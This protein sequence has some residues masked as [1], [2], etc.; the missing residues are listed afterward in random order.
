MIS[1]PTR[2]LWSCLLLGALGCGSNGF[3]GPLDVRPYV[4]YGAAHNDNLL[5]V[6]DS[7]ARSDT[8]HETALGTLVEWPVA[9][10]R[11]IA[12]GRVS[13]L[14]YQRFDELDHDEYEARARWEFR[15]GRVVYG[16]AGYRRQRYLDDFDNRQQAVT[17]FID[18]SEPSLETYVQ[19]HPDWRIRTLVSHLK[20]DHSLASQ[21]RF[22]REET[23]ASA[24]LQ[25]QGVESSLF[26]IGGEVIDG[27]FPGR[28][29][30]D[31][32]AE[33]FTQNS[34]F[35][36][37]DWKY[38]GISRL[39]GRLG[40]TGRDSTGGSDRD[41]DGVTGRLAYIR[42]LSA[43]TT[44]TGEAFRAIYSVDDVDANF[45][46]DT[47][48]LLSL[49]WEYSPK[50]AI[51]ASAGRR[52][53]NYQALAADASRRDTIDELTAEL[54]YQPT[55]EFSVAFTTAAA[56]RDSNL[57]LAN[58]DALSAGVTFRWAFNPERP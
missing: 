32:L 39:R 34:L 8:V 35:A 44:L 38:S 50:L 20:L 25:Y 9:N 28:S 30:D 49:N 14:R 45:V 12:S 46:R 58:Y 17:D 2:S 47:G 40:Y 5:A 18:V 37:F 10:Q 43:K 15:F 54:V 48:V 7:Q 36:T 33:S 16:S 52:E 19:V 31:P 6:P 1:P 41:F 56:Q 55:R 27:R 4:E 23:L 13:R 26:G 51:I 24:E 29:G 22:N 42:T 11:V 21:T 53:Q 57:A 3:A